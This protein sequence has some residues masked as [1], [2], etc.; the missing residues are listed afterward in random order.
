[1]KISVIYFIY[2][3]ASSLKHVFELGPLQLQYAMLILK[4]FDV[5][6]MS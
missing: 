2:P 3:D 5:N 6:Y 4:K 1:M